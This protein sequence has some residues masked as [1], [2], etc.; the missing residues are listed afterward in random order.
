MIRRLLPVATIAGALALAL[1]GSAAAG[2]GGFLPPGTYHF[3]DTSAF[4]GLSDSTNTT[5]A[6]VSVDRGRHHF[7]LR[8]GSILPPGFI[9]VTG[10]VLNVSINQPDGTF[11]NGC[12]IIPDSDFIVASGLQTASVNATVPAASNCPG[13]EVA[14]GSAGVTP[15]GGQ[16]GGGLPGPLTVAVTW[17]SLGAIA[18][19]HASFGTVCEQSSMQNTSETQSTSSTAS[20]TLSLVSVP[21]VNNFFAFIASGSSNINVQGTPPPNCL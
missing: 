12:W 19:S 15:H 7:A 13:F 17:N 21:L 6:F 9:A 5:S 18:S 11:L 20:G 3:T 4:A 14:V 2:G 16:G 1:G 8:Q 10:T